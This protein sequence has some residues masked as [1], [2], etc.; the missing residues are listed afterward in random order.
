MNTS[1]PL[2]RRQF[3]TLAAAGAAAALVRSAAADEPR[4]KFRLRYI[5]GSAMYG[6]QDLAVVLPEVKKTGAE[7]SVIYGETDIIAKYVG[8]YLASFQ[9]RHAD[10]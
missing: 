7:A 2:H 4:S 8:K 5:L 3:N 6:E 1:L 9:G 10:G